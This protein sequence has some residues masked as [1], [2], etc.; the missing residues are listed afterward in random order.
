MVSMSCK[1][2]QYDSMYGNYSVTKGKLKLNVQLLNI[3]NA[4][5]SP[6]KKEIL[7]LPD[8]EG[9]W[10]QYVARPYEIARLVY[11]FKQELYL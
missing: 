2:K 10:R 3:G 4:K 7:C 1:L 6:S 8:R 5:M 11:L 9:S